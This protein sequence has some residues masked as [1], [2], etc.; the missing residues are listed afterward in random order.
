[1][2]R[3]SFEALLDDFPRAHLVV[4]HVETLKATATAEKAIGRLIESLGPRADW[5]TG[6]MQDGRGFAVHCVFARPEDAQKLAA[7]V[8]AKGIG[9]YPGFA[10]Q[11]EFGL[12]A[13]MRKNIAAALAEHRGKE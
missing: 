8:Q 10:S 5:A 9:R 12:D 7:A 11:R 2:A 6:Q 3:R 4:G 13:A 1:M